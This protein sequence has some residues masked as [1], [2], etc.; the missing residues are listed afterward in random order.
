MSPEQI[1]SLEKLVK[2]GLGSPLWMPTPGPQLEAYETL[3]DELFYGGSAGSGKTELCIGLAL[4]RHQRSLILRRTNKEASKLVE[5]F[6]EIFEGR[7]GWNGQDNVWRTKDG[8]VID[9]GGCQHEDDRQKWKGTPHDLIAYD[10]AADF[11]ESQFRFISAWNRSADP[12][13]RCRIIAAGNPPTTPEG[14]WVINYW[15]PWLD[16]THPNPA[17]PGELRWF[18]TIGGK[19]TEVDGPGPHL[20]G[21]EMVRARSRT[22]IP[23][24]LEDN[25]FLARTDYAAVLSALPEEL[26]AAYKDGRFD[27]SL[28]DHP[29]QVIKTEWIL[30]AQERWKANPRSPQDAPM[31]AMGLDVAA[32][33]PDHTTLAWRYDCWYAPLVSVPGAETPSPSDAAALVVS[34][35]R[36]GAAIIVDV[37]GGYGGGV[38]ERLKDNR[39]EAVKFNGA[40]GA[41]ARSKD[42]ALTFAN[43]RAQAWW[44]LRE[45]LDPSQRDGSPICLPDDPGLRADLA[46][47]HWELTARGVLI[48]DKDDIKKR[49]GRSPDKGDAVVMAWSEGQRAVKRGLGSPH[50]TH[51]SYR[52]K[53]KFCT[54][55]DRVSARS[56]SRDR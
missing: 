54:M 12:S 44:A 27:K 36:D 15:A 49:L 56:W 34:H 3:A 45:A 24:R 18:T 10:E 2:T 21:N 51:S 8:R 32:G 6:V 31:T 7:D 1:A 25:P 40:H 35:R 20:I 23:G 39:I 38:V 4:T 52:E 42:R 13:Q 5:R 55:T 30:A 29:K 17:Q 33:G 28:R 22:F 53:P 47:P 50:L 9:V 11:T 48:E 46:A 14:L 41:T 19:D 26:R 16:A 43:K 37:G